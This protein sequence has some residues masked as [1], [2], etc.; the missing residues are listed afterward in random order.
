MFEIEK[1]YLSFLYNVKK[2]SCKDIAK[3][4]GSSKSAI[5]RKVN[6]FDI[7]FVKKDRIRRDNKIIESY[8]SGDSITELS[9]KYSLG[10]VA[11]SYLLKRDGIRIR[12]L[13]EACLLKS[14]YSTV[15]SDY[16]DLI[17]SEEKCYWLGFLLAD[18]NVN[19]NIDRVS[20]R[21]KEEDGYHLQK[22][23]D[24]F[25]KKIKYW[26]CHLK[27]ND[28]C[29]D[30]YGLDLDNSYLA[31]A[32]DKLG[33]HPQKSL[34]DDTTIFDNIPDEYMNHFIR[35]IFDGDGHIGIDKK[36]NMLKFCLCGSFGVLEKI[37]DVLIWEVGVKKN[38]ICS[39]NTKIHTIS[40]S[41]KDGYHIFKWIYENSTLHLERK[42]NVYDEFLKNGNL[43]TNGKPRNYD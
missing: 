32:V 30:G 38:K 20:M 4:V 26:T 35:G 3:L 27:K 36:Y 10:T 29:Y 12:G 25:E 19:K 43:T 2:W 14:K 41:G 17:D 39:G 23:A 8:L 18:G 7:N 33:I 1:E 11:I 5:N 21:L 16:F 13:D 24:I 34:S 15:N 22:L 28:K 31:K 37:R 9:K 40:W 6:K 42:R